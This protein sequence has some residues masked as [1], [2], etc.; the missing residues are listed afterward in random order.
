MNGRQKKKL[1]KK[2]L[3]TLDF[4]MKDNKEALEELAKL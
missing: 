3:K 4:V 2:F 1:S